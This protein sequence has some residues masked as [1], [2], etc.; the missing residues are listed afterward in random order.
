MVEFVSEM[1]SY[2]M[3]VGLQQMHGAA[4]RI[5]PAATAFPHRGEHYASSSFRT[6]PTDSERIV[7]WTRAFF[8]AMRTFFEEGLYVNNLGTKGK[9]G[10]KRPTPRTTEHIHRC[11]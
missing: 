7:E 10:C 4:S 5:N 3:G 6:V 9:T 8:E 2:T 11:S 1:P